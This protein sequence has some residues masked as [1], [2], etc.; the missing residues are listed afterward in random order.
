MLTADVRAGE[1]Q[2]VA[3]E[4]AEQQPRLDRSLVSRAVDADLDGYRAQTRS[5]VRGSKRYS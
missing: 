3:Q 2:L 5:L 4:V 1:A